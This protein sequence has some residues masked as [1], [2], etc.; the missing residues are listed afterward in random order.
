VSNNGSSEERKT[1]RP[2]YLIKISDVLSLKTEK[3]NLRCA[4]LNIDSTP[5]H[6]EP[7]PG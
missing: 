3:E 7:S 4:E 2:L 6:C 1:V 5:K